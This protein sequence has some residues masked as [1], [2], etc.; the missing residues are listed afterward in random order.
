MYD[1][2]STGIMSLIIYLENWVK[3]KVIAKY[4]NTAFYTFFFTLEIPVKHIMH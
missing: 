2:G 3:V 4:L 1:T